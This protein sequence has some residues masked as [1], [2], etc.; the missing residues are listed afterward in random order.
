MSQ[1]ILIIGATAGTGRELTNKLLAQQQEVRIIARNKEKANSL[2]GNTKAEIVI[3]DLTNPNPEFY[4][5]FRDVSDIF[6]TAAVPP[7]FAKEELLKKV[8]YNGVL[9]AIDAAKKA[10]F[11]G[12]FYYMNTIGLYHKSF[13]IRLLN[14]IKKNLVHWRIETEKAIQDSGLQWTIVRAGILKNKPSGTRPI[15]LLK[16]DIPITFS[17]NIARADV[18]D[19]L[20]AC[21]EESKTIGK[22]ISAIWHKSGGSI[23]KQLAT[24]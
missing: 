2:F 13:F 18:A 11:T 1:K 10:G 24:F 16:E 21:R 7:G 12:R 5:A 8:D 6:F 15:K 19:V 17:T 14:T 4:E 3:S 9:L 20:I 22:N 23:S